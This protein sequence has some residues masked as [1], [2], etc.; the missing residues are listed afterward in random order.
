MSNNLPATITVPQTYT[1]RMN[2][3]P[4]T[5]MSGS[6]Q[7]PAE[8]MNNTVTIYNLDGSV[9]SSFL[10]TSPR[11]I[12]FSNVNFSKITFSDTSFYL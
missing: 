7:M 6:I 12:T 5:L 2:S 1:F 4:L 10:V 3:Y 9:Q 11:S 8:H